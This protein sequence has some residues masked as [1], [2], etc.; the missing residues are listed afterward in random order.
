MQDQVFRD[1][2]FSPIILREIVLKDELRVIGIAE[3][4]SLGDGLYFV[5]EELEGVL[6]GELHDVVLECADVFKQLGGILRVQGNIAVFELM[7]W[8]IVVFV[9]RDELLL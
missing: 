8:G 3:E 2:L 7:E 9:D 5:I 1:V 6:I 4:V